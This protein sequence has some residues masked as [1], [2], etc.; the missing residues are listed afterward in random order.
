MAVR[1]FVVCD[2]CDKSPADRWEI[3][4]DES[5]RWTIELCQEHAEPLRD[6]IRH[7]RERA[8]SEPNT[9]D[10]ART[11]GPFVRIPELELLQ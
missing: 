8:L 9:S 11:F 10:I 6:L 2:V 7:G 5:A 3:K 4:E 1:T